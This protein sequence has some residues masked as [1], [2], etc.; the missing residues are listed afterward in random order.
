[1][2]FYKLHS[3]NDF[4]SYWPEK[5]NGQV[6]HP[7]IPPEM[8]NKETRVGEYLGEPPRDPGKK[9]ALH[10]SAYALFVLDDALALVRE[11][12]RNHL[13]TSPTLLVG[14]ER[15]TFHQIWVTNSV[16]CLDVANTVAAPVIGRGRPQ[17][18]GVIQRPVFDQA[19]WDGSDLFVVPQDPSYCF[20]CSHHFV[21]RW[22]AARF[23][24]AMFSRFLFD[25]NAIFS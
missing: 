12:A 13:L 23:R 15:E 1:M 7:L 2:N 20:Y 16:D 6:E 22:Q 9:G 5:I 18:I 3:R 21:E 24:G 11:A 17:E 19:R 25:P 4:A 14:R 8:R 10:R